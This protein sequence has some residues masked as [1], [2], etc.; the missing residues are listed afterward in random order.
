M[1]NAHLQAVKAA[2]RTGR[3]IRGLFDRIGTAEHP[4]GKIP[5]AYRGAHRELRY[6]YSRG[7]ATA[8]L[9]IGEVLRD[10]RQDVVLAV[11]ELLAEGVAAG[12]VLGR[13]QADVREIASQP[14]RVIIDPVRTA[15]LSAT[16][17]QLNAAAA[18]SFDEFWLLGDAEHAGI[19]HPG[20]VAREGSRWVAWAVTLGFLAELGLEP[21]ETISV[22]DW[23]KQAVAGIDER[24]TDCC[25]KVHG[26][27]VPLDGEFSTLGD[28]AWADRQAWP[29]FHWW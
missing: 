29:A 1:A 11:D 3:Q 7:G 18:V 26:Q 17:A 25:L 6:I 23:H 20:P 27:V 14:L 24:T 4:R 22:G 21:G 19:L 5:S 16:E 2:E 15:W 9:E 10:L 12:T 13:E 28:P 8:R